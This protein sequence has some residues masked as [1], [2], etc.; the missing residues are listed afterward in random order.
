MMLLALRRGKDLL[1]Y[2]VKCSMNVEKAIVAAGGRPMMAKTG[3][4]F[5][6]RVLATLIQTL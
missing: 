1:I 6:K 4:S 3:H 2:D 5:M